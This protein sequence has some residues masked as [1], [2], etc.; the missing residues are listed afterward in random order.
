MKG[1]REHRVPLSE[2]ALEILNALPR[3]SDFVFPGG[4]KGVAISAWR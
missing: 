4:R 3:E 2:R 1:K